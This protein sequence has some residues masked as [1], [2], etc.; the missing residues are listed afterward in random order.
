[1]VRSHSG[2]FSCAKGTYTSKSYDRVDK[3]S[4]W[5]CWLRCE[6]DYRVEVLI[7]SSLALCFR[8]IHCISMPI[9]S[10]NFVVP[11]RDRMLHD[12]QSFS[13]RLHNARAKSI[14]ILSLLIVD[15]VP[16]FSFTW[17]CRRPNKIG[18]VYPANYWNHWSSH[19]A[20]SIEAVFDSRSPY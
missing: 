7:P 8:N 18:K 16:R 15:S 13:A 2:V 17:A 10:C 4:H 14:E 6:P 11:N 12:E 5:R 20:N 9:L 3:Q 1:M 19:Q